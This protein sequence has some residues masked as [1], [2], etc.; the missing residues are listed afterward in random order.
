LPDELS[1]VTEDSAR[2][3]FFLFSGST[4]ATI[5]MAIAAIIV[6]R[7]LGNDAYGQYNLVITVPALI[8]LFTDL[9]ISTG[10]TKFAADLHNEGNDQR[11][12]RIIR[13]GLWFRLLLG[14]LATA[15]SIVFAGYLALIVNR[16][17]YAFYIQIVSLAII[18][19]I[20]FTTTNAAFVGLDKTEYNA[21]TT[22]VQAIA[23]TVLQVSFVLVTLSLTGVLIGYVGGYAIGAIAGAFLLFY[24][25]MRP[26]K[27]PTKAK[28]DPPTDSQRQ[29]LNLLAHYGWPLYLSTVLTGLVPLYQK[30]VLGYFTSNANVGN[31]S[32]ASNFI[33]LLAIIPSSITTA[34]LPA[35]SKLGTSSTPDIINAFFKRA[36]KYTCILIIPTATLLLIFSNQ[37]VG[38]VMG[39]AYSP[40][41]Q[42]LAFSTLVYFL[43]AFGSLSLTSLFNGLAE[44]RLTLKVALVSL[45]VVIALSPIFAQI[46]GVVGVVL[47]NFAGGI[48]ST[49]YAA[50]IGVHK[51]K[52]QFEA[53]PTAKIYLAGF[54]ATLLPLLLL[55][56]IGNHYIE[57]FLIGAFLYLL[58]YITITPLIGIVDERELTAL[59]KMTTKIRGLNFFAK[60][61]IQYMQKIHSLTHRKKHT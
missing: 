59:E 2:G 13:Y 19:Q 17:D 20:L 51:L 53:K 46:D 55:H 54:L 42:Y 35:F 11:A 4:L 34:L 37:V 57:V 49:L 48:A 8:L 41:A 43:A 32:A 44:T 27:R 28:T 60:P 40:A 1:K 24:K 16:P 15:L 31:Y 21:L 50:Y 6:A 3:G 33:T 9:G 61:V 10:I 29:I 26:S 58:I 7:R 38:I 45:I 52:V 36:N 12:Y 47:A 23:K 5:I 14:I 56:F 25:L 22:N 30:A 39:S 18:F